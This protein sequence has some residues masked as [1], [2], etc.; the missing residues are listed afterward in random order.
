MAHKFS[1]IAVDEKDIKDL[2]SYIPPVSPTTY[3][4]QLEGPINTDEVQ[5]ALRAG[6][7][8][9]APGIDGLSLEFYTAN[10]ETIK[11]DLTELLNHM[12]QQNHIPPRLKQ[13]TI[14]CLPK[15]HESCNPDD[16]RPI[17]LLNTDYKLLARILAS[18]LRPILA[19]QLTSSQY[20]GVP[21][22]SIFDALAEIRDVIGQYGNKNKPLCLLTLDFK[23]AFDRISHQYVF[24][25]IRQYW[26][27]NWYAD[28]LKALYEQA[29]ASVQI[30]GTLAGPTEIRSGIR[31]GCPL[32]YVPILA[33][34]SSSPPFFRK[35]KP[36]QESRLDMKLTLLSSHMQ[37]T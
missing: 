9:R 17:S 4:T 18:R 36:Y 13:G 2:L 35:K 10:W 8:H 23:Q 29:Q 14:I 30:N 32:E 11:M 21:G 34:P 24:T 1:P 33:L 5:S 3:A 31:Q 7:R 27:S 22:K 20:C 19:E 37:M 15:S 12:F 16:F 26:I 6:A 25:I 28:R